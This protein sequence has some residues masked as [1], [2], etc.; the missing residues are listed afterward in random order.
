MLYALGLLF[1]APG[2]AAFWPNTLAP[3]AYLS[4]ILVGVPLFYCFRRKEIYG[5]VPYVLAGVLAS[6]VVSAVVVFVV[7]EGLEWPVL[8][9]SACVSAVYALAAV[10]LFWLLAGRKPK[11]FVGGRR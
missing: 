10:C 1:F 8:L 6:L 3:V 4:F 11:G 5:M 9:M 2:E 7:W